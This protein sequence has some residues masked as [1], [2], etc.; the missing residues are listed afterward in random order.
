MVRTECI[1]SLKS[2]RFWIICAAC[3]LVGYLFR[4]GPVNWEQQVSI[5][6][7]TVPSKEQQTAFKLMWNCVIII[8]ANQGWNL[9]IPAG[10]I[11]L[12]KRENPHIRNISANAIRLHF[13]GRVLMLGEF[14][15]HWVKSIVL[16]CACS[17]GYF[18]HWA[19]YIHN[20]KAGAPVFS[21]VILLRV[22]FYQIIFLFL[23]C[24]AF[25]LLAEWLEKG[26]IL[27]LCIAGVCAVIMHMTAFGNLNKIQWDAVTKNYLFTG[28]ENLSEDIRSLRFVPT[29][30]GDTVMAGVLLQIGFL[31][32]G[33]CLILLMFRVVLKK[34]NSI[35]RS[36]KESPLA[37]E[38]RNVSAYREEGGYLS[39]VSFSLRKGE[40]EV[41]S[42]YGKDE[43]RTLYCVIDG[44][45]RP[46]D[47]EVILYGEEEIGFAIEDGFYHEKS[48]IRSELSWI[49][50]LQGKRGGAGNRTIGEIVQTVGLDSLANRTRSISSYSAG[51]KVLY[52]IA[53]ALLTDPKVLIL[54][55]PFDDLSENDYKLVENVILKLQEEELTMLYDCEG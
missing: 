43:V 19:D 5:I 40:T 4:I 53:A 55:G 1:R 2:I 7:I 39:D 17:L 38:L 13:D 52:R 49:R 34:K 30:G 6:E 33:V 31:A 18:L 10:I 8:M 11:F 45:I 21:V 41:L 15:G 42:R 16:W 46:T 12:S 35:S 54:D 23:I 26:S 22:W 48:D 36:D 44:E 29:G 14:F 50:S 51:E 37:L 28:I 20:T 27:N 47:G 32:V 3:L 24:A 9:L 25:M